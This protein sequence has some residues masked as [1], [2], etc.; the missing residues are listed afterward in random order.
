VNREEAV[1]EVKARARGLRTF[2]ERYMAQSPKVLVSLYSQFDTS[3]DGYK[4][5]S[6]I[7]RHTLDA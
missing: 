7:N 1:G 3:T 4:G 6:D 5:H 2:G